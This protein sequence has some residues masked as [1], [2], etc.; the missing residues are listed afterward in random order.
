MRLLIV[1]R[2]A[3]TLAPGYQNDPQPQGTIAAQVLTAA[4][5]TP[6]A[7]AYRGETEGL[8]PCIIFRMSPQSARARFRLKREAVAV[9]PTAHGKETIFTVP[10][11]ATIAVLD[12]L[13]NTTEANRTVEV[14]WLGRTL[15]MFA[16]DILERGERI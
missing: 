12:D 14:Q 1:L 16:D 8:T 2:L 13:H 9:V 3:C 10:A 4:T 11:N 7:D 15:Q 5:G 6:I